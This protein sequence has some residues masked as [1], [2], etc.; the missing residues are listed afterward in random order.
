[1]YHKTIVVWQQVSVGFFFL[2]VGRSA[3]RVKE[4]PCDLSADAFQ[5]FIRSEFP[6]LKDIQYEIMVADRKHCLHTLEL[7]LQ[8][9]TPKAIRQC[10]NGH[11]RSALYIRPCQVEY[12]L[13]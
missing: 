2:F 4:V 11:E 12:H 5:A 13:I 9:V 1:M 6:Y 3:I 8:A 7:P 10:N